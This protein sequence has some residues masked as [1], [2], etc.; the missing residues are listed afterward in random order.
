MKY[1]AVRIGREPG[2]Y[3][4]WE[5]CLKQVNEFKGAK[6]KKFKIET[7]AQ[8]YISSSEFP[9]L[10]NINDNK[11]EP[12]LQNKISKNNEISEKS[13]KYKE[14]EY[15][16]YFKNYP[17][18]I[19]PRFNETKWRK[20]YYIFTDGSHKNNPSLQFKSGYGVY[21]Y[22]PNISNISGRNNETNNYCEIIA[23]AKAL[24]KILEISKNDDEYNEL[25]RRYIVV[26]DSQ[27]C[28]KSIIQYMSVWKSNNWVRPGN[29][30]IKNLE[31]WKHIYKLL[32]KLNK[33]QI[34][35]GFMHVR[36]HKK[37]PPNMNS[38]EFYLWYGNNSADTLACGKTLQQFPIGFNPFIHEI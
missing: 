18:F 4:T 24:K 27:Y 34:S 26:S 35:V 6:Y 15:Y 32:I 21:F 3:N 8:N 7:E 28:L 16:I 38:F 25:N 5:E 2:I 14:T 22:S 9:I 10:S 11:I 33:Y 29:Q 23:I 36:S 30:E 17:G 1:Y 37:R 12:K 19:C 13:Q 31:L 20:Y